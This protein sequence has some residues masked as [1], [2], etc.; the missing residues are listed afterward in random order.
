MGR[1]N[2]MAKEVTE[3]IAAKSDSKPSNT[4]V[5]RLLKNA[6]YNSGSWGAT[7]LIALIAT[8]YI[9][10]KLTIEGYGVYA[11]LIG[12]V[13]YYGLL[14]LGLG[15]GVIKF[16]SEYKVKEDYESISRSI[17]AALWVQIAAGLVGSGALVIFAESIL[18]LLK[19]SPAL[20]ADAKIGLYV[21]AIGFFFTMLSGTLSSVLMGLQ[22]YDITSKVNVVTNLLLTVLI[23]FVLFLGAGLKEVIFLTVASAIVMFTIY[24]LTVRKSLPQ[25]RFS[26]M[27]DKGYFKLLFSF[28]SFVFISRVSNIF[29]NYIARFVVAFFLGPAAVTYYVVPSKV[30]SAFGGSLSSAFGVLFPFAS[31]LGAR[32]NYEKVQKTFIEASKIFAALS[33]PVLLTV[34]IFSKP[35]LTVWMGR[36]FAEKG[37][38][39]LRLL[40]ISGLVGSLT[41]VPNLITIGLGYSRVIGFFSVITVLFYVVLLPLLTKLWGIEGTA[42]AML[43]AT[44]PGIALVIYE[45][46]KIIHFEM[47][48]YLKNVIGFHIIPLAV[49]LFWVTVVPDS[50]V[51][52]TTRLLIFSIV[53]L[54]SYFGFMV[55]LKWIQLDSLISRFRI[56]TDR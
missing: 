31:E 18:R 44:I 46:K 37:W 11:L 36:E 4:S 39:V 45:T 41:T 10:H 7:V 33:V 35:I 49:S 42:W 13:G 27:L 51:Y 12:L 53:F 14:D 56:D 19:V 26:F 50:E 40:A 24:L 3:Q 20:W 23:V 48:S 38:I 32:K 21:S 43:G 22:R 29:S 25:W 15:Q 9:V 16:V 54:A 47:W 28:S 8:P 6:A 34:F 55:F 30:I 17:N 2:Q 5:R 1:I 52:S